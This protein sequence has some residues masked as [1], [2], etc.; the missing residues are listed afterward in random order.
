MGQAWEKIY[1]MSEIK[2]V[3][4]KCAQPDSMKELPYFS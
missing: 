3:K 2:S 4:V 1:P